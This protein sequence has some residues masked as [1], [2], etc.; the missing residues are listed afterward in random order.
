MWLTKNVLSLL[1][2]YFVHLS[3]NMKL[4]NILLSTNLALL[5]LLNNQIMAAA[6]EDQLDSQ[7]AAHREVKAA[8]N[9]FNPKAPKA[10]K[11]TKA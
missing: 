2:T 4:V 8:K 9:I 5:M 3:N 7:W 1:P 6:D 11:G 10:P